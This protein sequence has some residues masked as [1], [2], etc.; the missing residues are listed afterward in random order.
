MFT[1][2]LWRAA[3]TALAF[4][5]TPG[6][7][8]AQANGKLQIHYMDVGQGDGAVVISPQGQVV[9][10]DNGVSGQCSKPVGYLQS[11]GVTRID[12]HIA[13]H[14]H[15]D[16]IGCTPQ[17]L[18][19]F[20]LQ[21]F[22]Y[23]RGG[24]YTTATYTNYVNSVGARRRT[25]T[26]G[27]MLTLDAGTANPVQILFIAS[28]ANGITTNDENDKSLVAL[29]RFGNFEAVFG[30][31]L[32]GASGGTVDP[33]P[34]EPPPT[35]PIPPAGGGNT[36][37]RPAGAPANATAVCTD[38]AYSMSQN[39]QG[40]CSTHGGVR[41]WICPG[42]LCSALTT[43][44]FQTN[45]SFV[46]GA[47][48]VPVT[49]PVSLPS[50]ADI[51][52]SVANAVGQIEVYKV[53]HHGSRYSSNATWMNAT[54]PKIGVI[55]VGAGNSYGHPTADA[56]GRIHEIGTR[57]YW[58]SVGG[59]AAPVPGWDTV[60]GTMAVEVSPGAHAFTIRYGAEIETHPMWGFSAPPSLAGSPIG[61]VDTPPDMTSVAG[62]VAVTG[63]AID[64]SGIASVD[65]FRTA[66]GDEPQGAM[67]YIGT[68][69]QVEGARPDVASAFA[70]YPGVSRAG[71]GFMVLSNF[72]PNGG[73]G[74]FTLH[75][76]ARSL[77]GESAVI[78]S[79]TIL[80][81]NASS[82]FPFGTIDTPRQGETVSGVVTNFG[83]ALTPNPKSIP[84]D[85]STIDVYIDGVAVGH[86]TYNQYRPDVANLFP[87]YAN[88]N[89]AV[90][91][92]HFDSTTL[93]NGLHSISW[94]VRDN[95]GATQGVG[96]RY[97]R[98]Q[99]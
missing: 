18:A 76:V 90:G 59:G 61:V 87:G 83:W 71:W 73:N 81:A 16:H 19:A 77:S 4:I 98:V 35:Q 63:W 20:P 24:S 60:A 33:D 75:A 22:A 84:S 78:G 37:S 95:A 7:A 72:L 66:V 97:F 92:F 57:T 69:T 26:P 17:V 1:G 94:V 74:T 10:F 68:A 56:L 32:S 39:R 51:E 64:N 28:N 82:A 15:S 45:S 31:D 44:T 12:Y 85:G 88:S 3:V 40:T 38:G 8:R 55:S 36:C 9:L 21:Q 48:S 58:T 43:P 11:I 29:V 67:I 6:L 62:E 49:G 25:A 46:P 99:N 54:H 53:H 34:S 42:V 91:F 14:Y 47:W 86:P 89:G 52:S 65:I 2:T 50:Y 93:T 96:S 41:C 13:S 79:K 70:L 80:G 27:M 23:D 30:G 5:C